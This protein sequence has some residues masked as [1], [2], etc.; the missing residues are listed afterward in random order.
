MYFLKG[1]KII[2]DNPDLQLLID[3]ESFLDSHGTF[4]LHPLPNGLYPAAG[5]SE[6]KLQSMRYHYVWVRDNVIIAHWL[7]RTG[8]ADS[9]VRILKSLSLFFSEHK[10]RFL[11]IIEDRVDPLIA[12]DR[13]H[14]RFDGLTLKELDDCVK[15][16]GFAEMSLQPN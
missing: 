2:I 14:V 4:D 7:Y 13:P 12:M 5:A 1:E 9:A 11:D 3:I 10:H 6:G 15:K 16:Q 8:R